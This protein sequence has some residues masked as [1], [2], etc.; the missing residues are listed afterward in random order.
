MNENDTQK[1]DK[2]TIKIMIIAIASFFI[3]LTLITVAGVFIY[4]KFFAVDHDIDSDTQPTVTE[5]RLADMVLDEGTCFGEDIPQMFEGFYRMNR[6]IDDVEEGIV[7]TNVFD[8][9]DIEQLGIVSRYQRDGKRPALNTQIYRYDKNTD[10]LKALKTKAKYK[11]EMWP[12]DLSLFN[13]V[14]EHVYK[15]ECK[16]ELYIVENVTTTQGING[17]SYLHKIWQ[18]KGDEL[19]E[20]IDLQFNTSI[21]ASRRVGSYKLNGKEIQKQEI[22]DAIDFLFEKH[23]N[24]NDAE[25]NAKQLL[26]N[27]Y[28]SCIKEINNVLSK[29]RIAYATKDGTEDGGYDFQYL[30]GKYELMCAIDYDSSKDLK[31]VSNN[32]YLVPSKNVKEF[33][34]IKDNYDEKLNKAKNSARENF[35]GILTADKGADINLQDQVIVRKDGEAS[36][37]SVVIYDLNGDGVD[38]MFYLSRLGRSDT[39]YNI[40]YASYDKENNGLI[41][42]AIADGLSM[43][44]N[45]EF[46]SAFAI[47]MSKNEKN[48]F[49]IVIASPFNGGEFGNFS[50]LKYKA[51]EYGR[52]ELQNK[53]ENIFRKNIRDDYY[54]DDKEVSA[55]EGA[56]KFASIS[57]DAGQLLMYSG[58]SQIIP[59]FASFGKDEDKAISYQEAME[60]L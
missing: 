1:R 13:S 49:Y 23:D 54:I 36:D 6:K 43:A 27:Y 14:S 31:I 42:Y 22:D 41:S 28:S 48:T 53:L 18:V 57:N 34:N 45:K 59:V 2:R 58:D 60:N 21:I 40:I 51:S 29:Y 15:F 39:S 37:K 55:K 5:A 4:F 7:A 25:T 30:E 44:A 33:R 32:L 26:N 8:V 24:A 47:Y 20:V 46:S 19:V 11:N 17:I 52:L 35:K 3:V 9:K 38:E 50:V 10:E 16:G 56:T 12:I